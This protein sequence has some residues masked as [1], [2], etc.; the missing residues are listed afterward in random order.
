M[1]QIFQILYANNTDVSTNF[2]YPFSL[3][4]MN[5]AE[6]KLQHIILAMPQPQDKEI[7]WIWWFQVY[8]SY[9]LYSALHTVNVS[10]PLQYHEFSE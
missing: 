10:V 2:L 4:N 7:H 3:E 1:N 5:V 8:S 9:H 6:G